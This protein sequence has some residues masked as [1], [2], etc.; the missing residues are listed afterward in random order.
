MM[1]YIVLCDV[2]PV[3][4]IQFLYNV[5]LLRFIL[6]YLVPCKC[7]EHHSAEVQF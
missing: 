4:F 6:K 7:R 5:F 1:L 3:E 2:D